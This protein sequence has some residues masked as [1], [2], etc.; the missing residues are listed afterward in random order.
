VWPRTAGGGLDPVPGACRSEADRIRRCDGGGIS[1]FLGEGGLGVEVDCA[2]DRNGA[3]RG[4]GGLAVGAEPFA[5]DDTLGLVV[6][7]ALNV[8]GRIRLWRRVGAEAFVVTAGSCLSSSVA[9]WL[10]L[11]GEV[12]PRCGSFLSGG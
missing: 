2:G 11:F 8:L 1:A 5:E 6:D 12:P 3:L 9:D 10:S 4:D 7:I